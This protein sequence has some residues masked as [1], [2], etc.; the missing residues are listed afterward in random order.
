MC[1]FKV[2]GIYC[3]FTTRLFMTRLHKHTETREFHEATY[4]S[5]YVLKHKDQTLLKYCGNINTINTKQNPF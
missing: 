2:I 3:V 5:V 4:S 1:D